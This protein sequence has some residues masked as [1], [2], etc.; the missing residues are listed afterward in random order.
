M[1]TQASTCTQKD[2]HK[3]RVATPAQQLNINDSWQDNN[4]NNLTALYGHGFNLTG[5]GKW[6]LKKKIN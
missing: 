6:E 5:A 4:N 1:G 2:R 3:P